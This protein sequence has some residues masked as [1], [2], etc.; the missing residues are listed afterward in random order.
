M[1]IKNHISRLYIGCIAITYGYSGHAQNN[2]ELYLATYKSIAIHEM[3]RSGIPASITLAQGLL[4]SGAGQSTLA[5]EANNHFG[6]KCSS[7]WDGPTYYRKDDDRNKRGQLIKSCF[8]KYGSASESYLA[9]SVFL[10]TQNRYAALFELHHTDYKGWAHG[11]KK[12]GY[13]TDPAYA[14][15]LIELIDKYQLYQYDHDQPESETITEVDQPKTPSQ[16]RRTTPDRKRK[17]SQSA[18]ASLDAKPARRKGRSDASKVFHRVSK[19]ETLRQIAARYELN[20]DLLR[21]RNRLPKDAQVVAG[22]KIFL[23]KKISLR[24][25]PEF[26]RANNAVA[27]ADR[28]E[29]IF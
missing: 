23:R 16:T 18:V 22:E 26:T 25:R 6:I 7:S 29:F 5:R 12:A 2:S 15:K 24:H 14:R 27:N 3:H 1:M 8:R 19:G 17:K 21:L 28:N 11:L 20:E 10:T 13:A 4:E 9:H